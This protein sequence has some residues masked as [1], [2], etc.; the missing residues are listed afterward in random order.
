MANDIVAIPSP[1]DS[2]VALSG[3]DAGERLLRKRILPMNQSFVHPGNH[4]TKIFV[5]KAMAESLVNNFKAGICDIVQV[6]IVNKDNQHTEDPRD[7]AGRVTGL[8]YDETGVYATIKAS[9]YAEDFGK[10]I[11]GASAFLHLNY[12]DSATGSRVGPTL[13]HVAATNRPHINGLGDFKDIMAASADNSIENILFL[14]EAEAEPETP[15]AE[16]EVVEEK[17][18]AE[19]SPKET[20]TNE[21]EV[22]SMTKEEALAFLKENEGIDVEALQ[23]EADRAAEL[24]AQLEDVNSQ[25]ALSGEKIED[26]TDLANAVVALTNS[27]EKLSGDIEALKL[28]NQQY[29]KRDAENE[30]EALIRA[31]KVLPAQKDVMVKLSM[32]DRETFDALVPEN[33]IVKL[34][35]EGTTIHEEP[36]HAKFDADIERYKN[37]AKNLSRPIN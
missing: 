25:L 34:S 21:K 14:S 13:L 23:G 32:N 9:K 27:N 22:P 35:E 20:P 7:N 5:D 15:S 11:L 31:G 1:E 3:T 37:L 6:P 19:V 2:Y 10:T 24:S 29:A 33:P 18:P 4:K 17:K 30:V 26:V 28:S 16:T 8:D 12:M 36:N